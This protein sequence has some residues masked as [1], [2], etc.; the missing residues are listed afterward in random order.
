MKTVIFYFSGT[1]N[2]LKIA[3]DL[4]G[5]LPDTD[6]VPIPVAVRRD[7]VSV[8]GRAGF[9][10]PV[11][12]LG[13]PLMVA[14][15]IDKLKIDPRTYIFAIASP[16]SVSG[17]TF[18]QLDSRL[19]KKGARLSC[20][21]VVTMPNNYTPFGGAVSAEKQEKLFAKE[22]ARVREIAAVIK[23]GATRRIENSKLPLKLLG[24]VISP[25]AA[26]MMRGEDRHFWV[27]GSCNGCG[28]CKNVC[29]AGNIEIAG[30]R[31]GWLH[32]CE[33]CF[34]CFQWCP[35][36]AVQ[37][38]KSTVGKKRYHNPNVKMKDLIYS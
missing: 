19:K 29:P 4:A 18:D 1:G 23:S 32:R 24:A 34:A 25:F 7:D 28:T 13:V 17:N 15:F 9:V 2:C 33:Q 27:T 22:K 10:F 3:R 6:I 11:Y 26:K 37:Y 21:F 20:G 36:E 16:A 30:N 35:R 14:D 5:E 38:G 12:A 31:P 8:S